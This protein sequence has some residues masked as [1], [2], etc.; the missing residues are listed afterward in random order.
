MGESATTTDAVQVFKLVADNPIMRRTLSALSK[1][2][3]RD[4]GNRL[5]IALELYTGVRS[6]ACF[7]CR[8]AKKLLMPVLKAATKAF[9]V[10]EERLKEKFKDPYWRRGLVNVI[11]GIG[12]FGV[13]HPYVPG[14][15]FQIVWNITRACN[16]R[17]VHCYENAGAPGEDELSTE[18]ILR[19]IDILG[20]A[21]VLILAFSGG[22]PTVH[23]D[24]LKFVKRASERGMYVAMATNG[25]VF[26]SRE[27]LKEYKQ[28]GLQFAQISLDGVNP[29]THDEFRGVPGAFE[30]TVEGIKNCVA[31]GLFVEI[32][33]TL[34]R[35]NYKE[36]PALIE[37]SDKLGADWF[38]LYN[39]VPTGRGAEMVEADLS[40]EEREEILTLCWNKMKTMRIDVLS[41]APY[42]ARIAQQTEL[43]DLSQDELLARMAQQAGGGGG[44]SDVVPTHFYNP[45]LSGQLRRLA[46]FIGGCGCGRFYLSV[47]PNGDL[48]PCVFFPHEEQVKVG[49]LLEDDF[50]EL[51]RNSE[52]LWKVRDKDRL[53]DYC[54]SCRFRY[55]CGGCRAR[56]YNYYKDVL[57]PD[58]GC[59]L[60]REYWVKLKE[61]VKTEYTVQE[62]CQGDLILYRKT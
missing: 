21:G 51:W 47:E 42:F 25:L 59:I 11:K 32:A 57:A 37:F 2:C 1:R 10:T 14:A 41:T 7:R 53:A 55:T 49:N 28:A 19:G 3:S 45:K 46:D 44:D 29:K 31:E 9:G 26:S 12:W 39:F 33:T 62:T 48:Y 36:I 52:F 5:E 22:E 50:E 4:E 54:G 20:D 23:P 27:R 61:S 13:T 6:E 40:P 8:V 18:E 15:P 56:A 24:I 17:C 16:M 34:T 43:G 35:Q 38:M 30:K 60:N 58:P